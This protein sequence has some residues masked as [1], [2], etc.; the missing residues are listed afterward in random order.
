MSTS[1]N[2]NADWAAFIRLQ[3]RLEPGEDSSTSHTATCESRLALRRAG[4]AALR[5]DDGASARAGGRRAQRHAGIARVED[6][7]GP[8]DQLAVHRIVDGDAR[9]ARR[10]ADRKSLGQRP[11]EVLCERRGRRVEHAVLVGD[12]RR[13]AVRDQRLRDALVEVGAAATA[14]LAGI[15]EHQAEAALAEDLAQLPL[16]EQELAA[17]VV[18]EDQAALASLL[19]VD[20]VPDEVH[21]LVIPGI[22]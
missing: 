8:V 19:V 9:F 21:D 7:Y 2:P 14:A 1:S 4:C 18:F 17:A 11:V 20:A 16:A 10:L 6:R 22:R 12:E 5:R 15:Q 13:Q 3:R